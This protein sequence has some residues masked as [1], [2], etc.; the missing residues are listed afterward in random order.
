VPPSSVRDLATRRL[1]P[2]FTLTFAS[3]DT[4]AFSERL[5]EAQCL[6]GV[7]RGRIDGALLARAPALKLAQL[8]RK[9]VDK[10][11]IPACVERGVRVAT[12]GDLTAGAVAEH[13]LML[14]LAVSRKL[15]W[16]HEAVVS[17]RWTHAKPWQLP[18]DG[19]DSVPEVAFRGLDGMALGIVGL[20]PIGRRVATLASAFGMTVR[21]ATRTGTPGS[22]RDGIALVDL[23]QLLESSDIVSLHVGLSEHTRDFIGAAELARMRRGALLI[24]TARGQLV[25]E[26]ALVEA[27]DSGHIAGAGL[28]TLRSEPPEPRCPLVRH[29]GVVFTP[30]TGWLSESSWERAIQFGYDN[31]VRYTAGEALQFEVTK[32]RR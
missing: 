20:G 17:G 1:P 18:T 27:L 4:D 19:V 12:I 32:T 30:H 3:E 9:G 24:N 7:P 28:D 23:D 29:P 15:L 25:D 22:S 26:R 11:D 31:V 2:A 13:T 14:M 5:A 21:A 16:Q 8:L 10:V 6:F